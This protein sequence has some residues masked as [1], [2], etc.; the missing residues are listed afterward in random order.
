[1]DAEKFLTIEVRGTVSTSTRDFPDPSLVL[2]P[3]TNEKIVAQKC[4]PIGA[5]N[6]LRIDFSWIRS[7]SGSQ[8][9]N[10]TTAAGSGDKEIAGGIEGKTRRR[11]SGA[12]DRAHLRRNG[13]I[14]IRVN[15]PNPAHVRCSIR[16]VKLAVIV[17]GQSFEC[18]DVF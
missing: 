3:V 8:S 6:T 18:T 16:Y 2:C 9:V 1:L 5:G 7:Y 17:T 4:N 12:I 10:E 15:F 11:A 13:R 14:D